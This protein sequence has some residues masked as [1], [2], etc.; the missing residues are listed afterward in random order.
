[1]KEIKTIMSKSII[2]FKII[3]FIGIGTSGYGL[4]SRFTSKHHTKKDIYCILRKFT[5]NFNLVRIL[6]AQEPIPETIIERLRTIW[7][8]NNILHYT[9]HTHSHLEAI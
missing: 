4:N 9:L 8:G 5:G 3:C 2:S 6:A 1:M 7:I